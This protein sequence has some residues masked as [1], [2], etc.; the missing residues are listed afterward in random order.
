MAKTAESPVNK[1]LS[2]E[3]YIANF[4]GGLLSQKAIEMRSSIRTGLESVDTEYGEEVARVLEKLLPHAIIGASEFVNRFS[5]LIAELRP[6]DVVRNVMERR[7]AD[8]RNMTDLGVD[9]KDVRQAVSAFQK[10]MAFRRG[11]TRIQKDSGQ[12]RGEGLGD[13]LREV[14]DRLS[15][16]GGLEYVTPEGVNIRLDRNEVERTFAAAGILEGFTGD[17]TREKVL[18]FLCALVATLILGYFSIWSS[19]FGAG[20]GKITDGSMLMAV[21]MNP[22][23]YLG[24]SALLTPVSE[25]TL[26]MIRNDVGTIFGKQIS[27]DTIRSV[28]Q[29]L[30]LALIVITYGYDMST[31]YNGLPH[32]GINDQTARLLLT[33]LATFGLEF[34]AAKL[35][36]TVRDIFEGR[37]GQGGGRN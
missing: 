2:W 14:L 20:G 25:S 17:I 33:P 11:E 16:N 26:R 5:P 12:T 7:L 1:G 22:I 32:M 27:T 23:E 9:E 10:N 31:T 30:L 35:I 3:W 36:G 4:G 18:T 19:A 8:G 28:V 21:V 24:M 15:A 13:Y 29:L 34:S 37:R 6:N